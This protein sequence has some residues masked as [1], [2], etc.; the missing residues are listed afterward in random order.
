MTSMLDGC[1]PW[2][3]GFVDRYWA[4][5]HWRGTTLD[6]LLRGWAL[7]YGPR[8]AL[9]SGG[10]RITYAALNRRVDR[11]AAGLRL[12]ALRP[13]QRVVVQLPNVAEFVVTV[14]ALMRAG[15]VPV[16]CPLS[17]RGPEV[18]HLVQVTQAV[19]YV[20][21]STY[22][23]FDHTAMAADVA[24]RG[25]FLRRV[26]TLEAPGASSPYGGY[27][28]D[29]SGCHYFPLDS[30]DAPPAPALP[31]S[32]GQVAFLLLSA[33]SGAAGAAAPPLLVPR[34]HNDYA[35]QAGA[36]AEAVSLTED[37]VYLAALPASSDF[38]LGGP[39]IVGTLSVGG[40]VVLA[41]DPG[42]EACLAAIARERVTVT[43][44]VP[45]V[46]RRWLDAL[47][48]ADADAPTGLGSLRLVQVGGAPPDRAL[49][50]RL[51]SLLGCRPQQVFGMAEGLFTLTR[52]ADPDETVLATQG[53]PLSPDDEIRIVD[54]D[55]RDVPDGEPGELLA[56]G[57]YTVRGYY[58][59]PEHNARSFTGDGYFRTGTLARR[60]PGG[61]LVVTGSA[62]DGG[63]LGR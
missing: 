30:L 12:L 63:R 50:D 26:F 2:P 38:T 37:D 41:E 60:T 31:L 47:A 22:E 46:A 54:A 27:T 18:S 39:G 24:A 29:P 55:G 40:T 61:H 59:A 16:L 28:T 5:G 10:T 8:T 42:P 21:P 44:V 3:E 58:R 14:F 36:A 32:A 43:S 6:S 49:T 17:H 48:A 56:R 34:T 11:M 62:P 4:A 52:P 20:G 9:V 45:A 23:G 53:R 57:P 19:G 35:Y 13:G 25:P 7:Q 51:A 15:A 1:T 33:A